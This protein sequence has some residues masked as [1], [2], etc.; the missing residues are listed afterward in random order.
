M[1]TNTRTKTATTYVP[2]QLAGNDLLNL[3]SD[4]QPDAFAER[5]SEKRH[6]FFM[7][8]VIRSLDMLEQRS[9]FSRDISCDGIGLLHNMPIESGTIARLTV[10]SERPLQINLAEVMW[11][12]PAGEGWYLSGWRFVAAQ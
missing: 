7:P 9:A 6:T 10:A 12:R 1:K 2:A 5:R 11:C 3:L 8:V 4:S